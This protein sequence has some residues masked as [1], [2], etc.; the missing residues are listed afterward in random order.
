MY[1]C[2]EALQLYLRRTTHDRQHLMGLR[3]FGFVLGFTGPKFKGLHT[4]IHV[5][6]IR[7]S[8][9]YAIVLARV[10]MS[11]INHTKTWFNESGL[12]SEP[13]PGQFQS[14]LGEHPLYLTPIDWNV[15][16]RSCAGQPASVC[17][18]QL[19]SASHSQWRHNP[20]L[21]TLLPA[22]PAPEANI[23]KLQLLRLRTPIRPSSGSTPCNTV[24]PE[25]RANCHTR[26]TQVLPNSLPRNSSF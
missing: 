14:Y 12:L 25:F 9:R 4:N 5:L 21:S 22:T 18:G 11:L 3:I 16:M 15:G 1:P 6:A 17:L 2:H 8:P 13:N 23:T 19:A 7:W 20:M 10:W 26:S 24:F